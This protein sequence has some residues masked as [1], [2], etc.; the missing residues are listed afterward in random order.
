MWVPLELKR[1]NSV[2]AGLRPTQRLWHRNSLN[3]GIQTYGM[4]LRQDE[5]V[6]LVALRLSGGFNGDLLED[7]ICRESMS[8]ICWSWFLKKIA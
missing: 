5:S 2:V 3:L 6:S 7:E 1:G 8:E 4:T